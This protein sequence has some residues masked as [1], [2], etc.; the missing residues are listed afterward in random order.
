MCN[1]YCSGYYDQ[2]EMSVEDEKALLKEKQAILEA[3]LATVK[4]MLEHVEDK[5]DQKDK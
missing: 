4:Y 3:K 5:K 1:G 2:E